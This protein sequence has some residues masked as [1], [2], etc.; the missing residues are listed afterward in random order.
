MLKRYAGQFDFELKKSWADVLKAPLPPRGTTYSE[1]DTNI[2]SKVKE[3]EKTKISP[4]FEKEINR[5]GFGQELTFIVRVSD[6]ENTTK[7]FKEGNIL[8]HQ[9]G[10]TKLESLQINANSFLKILE[11]IYRKDGYIT[12]ITKSPSGMDLAIRG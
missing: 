4:Y 5:S 6:L 2:S 7:S 12:T 10:K 1:R 3:Y 9:V 11:G 8:V